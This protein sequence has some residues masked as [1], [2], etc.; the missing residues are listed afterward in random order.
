[1]N[2]KDLFGKY[3]T[4]VFIIY[5]ILKIVFE[6]DSRNTE[7]PEDSEPVP[8]TDLVQKNVTSSSAARNVT[9]NTRSRTEE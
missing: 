3:A 5:T 4:Y 2:P 1:M 7:I 9:R 6:N 8:S